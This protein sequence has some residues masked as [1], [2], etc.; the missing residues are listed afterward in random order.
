MDEKKQED[1]EYPYW[2]RVYIGVI[3]Y[4]IALIIG[5][6]ALTKSFQ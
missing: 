5:L 3:I 6:W 1:G 2:N 4:A